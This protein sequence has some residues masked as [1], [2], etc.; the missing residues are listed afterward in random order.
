MPFVYQNGGTFQNDNGTL[1][2]TDPP[3]IEA[4]QFYHG[5]YKKGIA[6]IPT[7][8]GQGWNGDTFGRGMAAMCLSGGWLIPFLKGNYPNLNWQVAE[9]PRGKEKATIAFTTAFSM[10]RS[11]K[12]KE[13]AWSMLSYLTG[14]NGMR[15]WTEQGLAL[16]SR[17]SVA[18]DNGFYEDPVYGVFMNSAEYAKTFQV[19]FSERGFEEM[20][21][22]MQAIFFTGKEPERAMNDIKARIEKYSLK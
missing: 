12:F 18:I 22:A 7:D 15:I 20:V 17:K 14:K 1:G 4:L 5:L 2:I 6:T 16:P 19:E 3:F 11:S 8:V 9:L 21:V 13:D 10:P